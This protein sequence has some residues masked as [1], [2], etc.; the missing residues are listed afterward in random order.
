MDEVEA[1]LAEAGRFAGEVIAPLN[2][3]GDTFGTP[4]KDGVVTTAPGWKEAYS[5]WRGG[6][7]NGLAAPAEWGGQALPQIDQHRLH[8]NVECGGHGLCRRPDVDHGGDRRA[9]RPRQRRAQAHLSAEARVRRMD[10]HHAAH[11]A[12]GRLRRRR[13]AHPRRARAPTAAIASRDRKSSSPM[14]STTSPKT[15][16]ISCWRACPMRR[17][18]RA[19]FRCS[20]CRN[21][22]SMP[23]ARSARATTC[24]PIR[25]STSSASTAR[26]PAP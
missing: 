22:C 9:A 1:V 13:A 7:W 23:T 19:A 5:A 4:F 10:G 14:A 26:R 15:S 17:R 6:G 25:S 20:W 24:A 8:R 2:R 16:S 12:A 11:R 21:F 3:V 18:A